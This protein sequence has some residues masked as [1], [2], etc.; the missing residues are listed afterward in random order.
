MKTDHEK[1]LDKIKKCLRLA[2]SSNEHEAAAALRQARKMMD[3]IGVDADDVA[4]SE[5]AEARVKA[6]AS[7]SPPMWEWNLAATVATAL[8]CETF[9]SQGLLWGSLMKPGQWCFVGCDG[10]EL[11]AVYAFSS[12][13]RR[14][15]AARA[16]YIRATLSRCKRSTKTERADVYCLGWVASVR[17]K[18]GDLSLVTE[19]HAEI[20]AYLTR[21]EMKDLEA[22]SVTVIPSRYADFKAG[23]EAGDGVDLRRPMTGG[24]AQP[25][26]LR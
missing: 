14:L 1:K 12:L 20:S 21:Y 10:A 18:L 17:S 3:E 4:A 7:N 13:Y 15:K 19:R 16:Q 8:G 23:K 6:A 22:G 25:E 11:I 2:K 26:A 9:F 5:A 24:A